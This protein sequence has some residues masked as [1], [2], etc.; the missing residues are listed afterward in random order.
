MTLQFLCFFVFL[1]Y[2]IRQ[3]TGPETVMPIK[4]PWQSVGAKAVVAP[5]K[6]WGHDLDAMFS[7]VS[8]ST[9]LIFIAN[10]NNPTGTSLGREELVKFLDKVPGNVVVVLDEAY[11]EYI[12]D[13]DFPDGLALL[14]AYPN[15]IVTR[16]FSKAWGLALRN[17]WKNRVLLVW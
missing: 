9:K 1:P 2:L 5:A 14:S 13:H 12:E 17:N 6:D 4:T 11:G 7:L 8:D 16:T 10:P 15:L 3:D